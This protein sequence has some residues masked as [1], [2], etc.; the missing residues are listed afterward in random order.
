MS[1]PILEA[2]Q[3]VKNYAGL[4]AVNRVSFTISSGEILGYLGP[5]GSGKS[6]TVKML[7]GL[8]EPTSGHIFFHGADIQADLL[9]YKHRFGYVPEES[10][11]YGFL[12]AWEYLDLAGTLRYLNRAKRE[13]RAEAMLARLS[14]HEHRHS[15]IASYSKGMRQRLMLIASL[16]HD[17]ELLIW[18][19]PFSG[20]D[21]TFTLIFRDVIEQLARA[22]KAIFFC[23]PV[24]EHVERICSHVVLLR[25]GEIVAYGSVDD[26]RGRALM[27]ALEDTFRQLTEHSDT[28][29][30]ARDLVEIV[31][32]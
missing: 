14:L 29:G 32:S 21:V 25:R 31:R 4:P 20:L 24:L 15:L 2:R 30:I 10:T 13:R 3:L 1:R 16:L 9:A 22:G 23:S 17:P 19:E 26:V 11:L 6:T 7:T 8:L 27:P 5:N 28:A 18:D 12:T